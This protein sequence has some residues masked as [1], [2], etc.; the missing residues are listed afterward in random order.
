MR[1]SSEIRF[2]SGR[3]RR[4]TTKLMPD[5][6]KLMRSEELLRIKQGRPEE[7]L[8]RSK[9]LKDHRAGLYSK[10]RRGPELACSVTESLGGGIGY[11]IDEVGSKWAIDDLVE[12]LE[13]EETRRRERG[14]G[15][16]ISLFQFARERGEEQTP[17]GVDVD[18]N[19]GKEDI[20]EEVTRRTNEVEVEGQGQALDAG[21]ARIREV[22]V[23]AQGGRK[24][25]LARVGQRE[26]LL[27][28]SVPISW[29]GCVALT[30]NTEAL[31]DGNE[32]AYGCYE[33]GKSIVAGP[34]VG[35]FEL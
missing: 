16:L 1:L 29:V 10:G 9:L 4:S 26:T 17:S 12:L 27:G 30:L 23:Q 28:I 21:C 31:E 33:Y 32:E 2:H 18:I 22:Q 6:L 13:K 5:S 15:E 19:E 35:T 20:S 7:E 3:L 34:S 24:Y 25:A 14:V 8:D 11:Q